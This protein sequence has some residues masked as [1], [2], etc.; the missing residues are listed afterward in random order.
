MTSRLYYTN[1]ELHEFD[2]V[3]AEVVSRNAGQSRTGV[4]LQETAFYPT[5]GGQVHDTG[6]L[7]TGPNDRVR[8]AEVAEKEDGRI[9][10]YLEAPARLSPGAVVHGS[11][12]P[13]RRRD[14][15]QQHSGQH[16]LSAAFVE[17]YQMPTVSFHM[18]ED[19]CSIDLATASLS[20]E[21]VVAAE[22][23]ANEVIFE[24]RP[25]TIR[26]V[27]RHQAE[28]LGLRKLPPAER[29]ELRL[30]E[31]AN[32]DL[33]ACGGTH[34]SA[35]GQIGSILLRKTE[36][37]RQGMRVEFVCGRRAV[38]TARRDYTA[39]SE[40]AGLFSAQLW[41]APA[42]IRKT[43][44]DGKLLR[45]QRDEALEQLAE[46]MAVAALQERPETQGRKVVV[47][48]FADRDIGF[49][50][51]FAQKVVRCGIPAIGLAASTVEPPGLVFAQSAG[52]TADMG[53]LLKQVLATVGGRGGGSRD[54]AQG[55]VPAGSDVEQ[56]L[57]QAAGTI[58]A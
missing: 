11:I 9:V 3:V 23:R 6:W 52:G 2:S 39:L 40:A 41:D 5:S 56:L 48:S 50:K 12:D 27:S 21:Q 46:A 36:R 47:R 42:Q 28:E 24:N 44:E 17:L 54:F 14:H 38:R 31:V 55:G 33:S 10:H 51:L 4:I 8:V 13:E 53:A 57:K 25:V 15:M 30:I 26:F 1:P 34:V 29:D 20:P 49:A 43:F 18:G 16:V 7:T 35:T 32:F 37:V 45:K 22:K 19:Y 58:G